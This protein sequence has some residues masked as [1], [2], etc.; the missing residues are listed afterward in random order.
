MGR[1]A[2]RSLP[3]ESVS[4][5]PPKCSSIFFTPKKCGL[6]FQPL[7]PFRAGQQGTWFQQRGLGE[8]EWGLPAVGLETP[9]GSC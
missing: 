2:A 4:V 9:R 5:P 7:F 8:E 1:Q 6:D 3:G